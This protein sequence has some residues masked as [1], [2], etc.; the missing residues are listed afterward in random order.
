MS[1]ADEIKVAGGVQCMLG[2]V[3]IRVN[4]PMTV[5]GNDAGGGRG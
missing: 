2:N 3:V 1:V 4:S 5:N